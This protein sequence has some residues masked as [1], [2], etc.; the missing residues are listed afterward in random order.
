M[1]AISC[2]M[3]GSPDIV[4]QDGVFVC[5][6]CGMKYSLEEA[7]KLMV[8]V[9]GPIKIDISDELN[10]LYIVAR[11]ARKDKNSTAAQR[12]YDQIIMKDPNSWEANFYS[13][14]FQCY[15]CKI[16]EIAA[17]SKSI[18]STTKTVFSLIDVYVSD[19]AE[20]RQALFDIVQSLMDLSYIMYMSSRQFFDELSFQ[21]T[22]NRQ[23]LL[24]NCFSSSEI[25]YLCGDSLIDIFGDTFNLYAVSA[26]KYAIDLDKSLLDKYYFVDINVIRQKV[27][28][29]VR[30]ILVYEKDFK[31]KKLS[32]GSDAN[33]SRL[34]DGVSAFAG[35][36]DAVRSIKHMF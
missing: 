7:K 12:F 22:K 16:A 21:D 1:K 33:S 2:E 6:H 18:I 17:S 36:I 9:S 19:T 30:K 5:Q 35:V 32:Y 24:Y 3:C 10:N 11:R 8:S 31:L 23:E 34:I 14:Y 13:V 4:K 20:R 29:Y 25:L 26:W 28:F 15:N 27:L